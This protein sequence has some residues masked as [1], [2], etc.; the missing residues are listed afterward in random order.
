M[1]TTLNISVD[2]AMLSLVTAKLKNSE[3]ARLFRA[4]ATCAAASDDSGREEAEQYLNTSGLRLAFALLSPPIDDARERTATLRANGA[5]GGRPRKNASQPS[6]NSES[7]E[8]P[9]VSIK[10]TKKETLS[11]TPPLKEK[12]KKNINITLS[13]HACETATVPVS[14][15]VLEWEELEERMLQE[16][17]WLD[18]LCMTRHIPQQDMAMYIMDFVAYLRE[19]DLRETLTHAKVHFVNQLPYIIKQY[20]TNNNHENNPKFITDPVTRREYERESRRK[21][22]CC[23]IAELAT[24][25]QRP[26]VDPF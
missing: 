18:Q 8:N 12:I 14:L 22:V 5:R 2:T 23:A 10:K 1:K 4:L 7:S 16:Q 24:Q 20:K 6:E 25:S 9:L 13:P 3:L 17:P 21:E 15:Q 26:A 11:P 19:R